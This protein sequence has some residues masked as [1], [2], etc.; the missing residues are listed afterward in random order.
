MCDHISALDEDAPG[1]ENRAHIP[2]PMP[3][4]VPSRLPLYNFL[5]EHLTVEKLRQL[6]QFET[7]ELVKDLPTG[8]VSLAEYAT[9]YIAAL[10]QAGRLDAKFLDTLGQFWGGPPE[11]IAALKAVLLPGGKR[12]RAKKDPKPT[13]ADEPARQRTYRHFCIILDRSKPWQTFKTRCVQAKSDVVFLAHGG[14]DQDLYLFLERIGRFHSDTRDELGFLSHTHLAVRCKDARG[15]PE[16]PGEW[17]GRLEQT[18]RDHLQRD[19]RDLA[20]ALHQLTE[21]SAGLLAI[22]GPDGQGLRATGEA[23]LPPACRV[24]LVK[25]IRETL[26]S[27]LNT[28]TRKHPLRLL[29]PVEHEP[30]TKRPLPTDILFTELHKAMDGNPWYIRVPELSIP[31]WPD[32]LTTI[33]AVMRERHGYTSDSVSEACFHA[34]EAAKKKKQNFA[35]IADAIGS[36]LDQH[37]PD[38]NLASLGR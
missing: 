38:P 14:H 12:T 5:A 11:K 9:Q 6:A 3:T 24:A 28:G 2:P 27:L 29:I 17:A 13:P 19:T 25:F 30:Y 36:I 23:G 33:E 31:D 1:S 7:S 15:F 32:V 37:F 20:D 26:P 4:E 35:A 10:V 8:T 16:G 18:I 21:S 22:H 34:Y